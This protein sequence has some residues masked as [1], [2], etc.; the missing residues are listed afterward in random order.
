MVQKCS[1]GLYVSAKAKAAFLA[2]NRCSF[3]QSG[4][5]VVLFA[6]NVTL[7]VEKTTIYGTGRSFANPEFAK[8]RHHRNQ[9]KWLAQEANVAT[10]SGSNVANIAKIVSGANV[11]AREGS[12][13]GN[14]SPG[15]DSY[16][17]IG[18][19]LRIKFRTYPTRFQ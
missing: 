19:C 14:L 18:K 5:A 8:L 1:T 3:T 10:L 9:F 6:A 4:D 13:S 2:I 11:T 16:I 15:G 7:R 12:L 17:C